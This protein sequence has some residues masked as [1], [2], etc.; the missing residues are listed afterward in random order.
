MAFF[1][2]AEQENMRVSRM[3]L[4]VVGRPDE[5]FTPE[6]EADVQEEGF[7]RA[8]I[9]AETGDPVHEFEAGSLVRPILE[10]MARDE[11]SFEQGGQELASLFAR[12]HVRQATSGA[13]FVFH[14]DVGD[15]R[16]RVY[17]L[18]KYDYREVVE[19]SQAEGRNV[20]RAIVQA[21]VK[22][23]KAVQKICVVRLVDGTA[24]RMV[25]A[26]DRMHAAPDL[27]DYF[28]K[29]LGVTRTRS[30]AELS[31]RL[32]EAMRQALQDVSE[33]LPPGGVPVALRRMKQALRPRDP[34][35][36]DDV[37]DAALHAADR[38]EDERVRAKIESKT[39]KHL[40]RQGLDD[41]AFRPEPRIF[42]LRP[43]EYVRTAEEVRI[44]YPA[45]QLGQTVTR[46]E[47]DGDITFTVT[48]RRIV[49]DGTLPDRSRPRD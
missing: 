25:S 19:L 11:V 32:H 1:T 36:N 29:Y 18:I 14:L 43:R 34:V 7:F 30:D 26:A 39:R 10:R 35:R 37:V 6:P 23:R 27:T 46:T 4:H 40:R 31:D 17:A 3:I 13:F 24:E 38:P 44:E 15:D 41:V 20:L 16:T 5:A 45:E 48:T 12:D 33:H 22:E 21:F 42:A 9:L 49:E 2:E 47:R 28:A 8:R